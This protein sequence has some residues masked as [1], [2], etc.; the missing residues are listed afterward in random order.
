MRPDQHIRRRPNTTGAPPPP[1]FPYPDPPQ[2]PSPY[3]VKLS[4]S[5]VRIGNAPFQSP[6]FWNSYDLLGLFL[7]TIG[8]AP[9][10]ANK[11]Q[12]FFPLT[13][14]YG[15]WCFAIGPPNLD[16]PGAG[17]NFPSCFQCTWKE[18]SLAL[19]VFF[20]GA[21]FGGFSG[22][23]LRKNS[24]FW[25]RLVMYERFKLLSIR[26]PFDESPKR[27]PVGPKDMPGSRYGNCAETYPFVSLMMRYNLR[28]QCLLS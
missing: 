13:A 10:S 24:F 5:E 14:M 3:E 12:F 4:K 22:N 8:P 6:P 21:S 1:P 16:R 15:W 11:K 27:G 9:G 17:V 26:T 23:G 20:L 2:L 18:V 19:P 25:R 7:S 28:W